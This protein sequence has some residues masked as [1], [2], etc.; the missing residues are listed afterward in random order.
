MC[1]GGRWLVTRHWNS[2]WCCNISWELWVVACSFSSLC[3]S[4]FYAFSRDALG[5]K[6]RQS[7]T[8]H[9][10]VCDEQ[11]Y[12]CETKTDLLRDEHVIGDFQPDCRALCW[13]SLCDAYILFML[14][15]SSIHSVCV[16]C[17]TDNFCQ[18]YICVMPERC[19]K[20]TSLKHQ[21]F[22]VMHNLQIFLKAWCIWIWWSHISRLFVKND[23]IGSDWATTSLTDWVFLDCRCRRKFDTGVRG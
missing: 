18:S 11:Q 21:E 16:S 4:V 20:F 13:L 5:W 9:P 17:V 2:D 12:V 10:T 22:E 1:L 8:Q 19:I 15:M 7:N 3:K 14:L 6:H 23:W